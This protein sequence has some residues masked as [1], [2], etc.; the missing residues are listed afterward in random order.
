MAEETDVITSL[1]LLFL[2]VKI[3]VKVMNHFLAK[4]VFTDKFTMGIQMV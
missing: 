1:E 2:F 4:A 3:S